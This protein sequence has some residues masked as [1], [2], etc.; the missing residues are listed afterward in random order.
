MLLLQQTQRKK[1]RIKK[2]GRKTRPRLG[3][4]GSLGQ[5]GSASHAGRQPGLRQSQSGSLDDQQGQCHS[6]KQ[7]N[8]Q[9]GLWKSLRQVLQ[10]AKPNVLFGFHP[11]VL[12][13]VVC[14]LPHRVCVLHHYLCLAQV[15]AAGLLLEETD[16]DRRQ[17]LAFPSLTDLQA[18]DVDFQSA[19][20]NC[21]F[22]NGSH[23][24]QEALDALCTKP[25]CRVTVAMSRTYTGAP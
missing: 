14:L 13:H 1:L 11:R 15:D 10:R 3:S 18:G 24:V 19:D 12:F 20:P 9:I 6:H 17:R 5:C 22:L 16:V 2:D 23:T 25:G 8:D 4:G 7:P 21:T